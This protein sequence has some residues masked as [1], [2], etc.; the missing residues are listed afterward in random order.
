MDIK[1]FRNFTPFANRAA[2]PLRLEDLAIFKE[3]VVKDPTGQQYTTGGFYPFDTGEFAIDVNGAALM[4]LIQINERILPAAVIKEKMVERIAD[5]ERRDQRKANKKDY[6]QVKDE[7]IA[8]LLPKSFIKR[9]YIPIL[10]VKGRDDVQYALVFTSSAK[11]A[12]DVMLSLSVALGNSNAA[13]RRWE[14]ALLSNITFSDIRSALNTLARGETVNED[15]SQYVQLHKSLV[16]KGENKQKVAI[17]E[18]DIGS[19]DVQNLLTAGNYDVAKIGL[20]FYDGDVDASASFSLTDKLIFSGVKMAGVKKTKADDEADAAAEALHNVWV[21]ARTAAD[22]VSTL[23]DGLGGL[24]EKGKEA[25][26]VEGSEEGEVGSH[27]APEKNS[28]GISEPTTG[29]LA[30]ATASRLEEEQ[31]VTVAAEDDDEL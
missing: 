21:V 28:S 12:D 2:K 8:A 14:P 30:A 18:K 3:F 22:M 27:D 7:A 9:T 17:T 4:A 25:D 1:L 24:R 29:E 26:R 5:I 13:K 31:Q 20:E 6:A 16:V 23:V 11:K 10:F 15:G 19:A